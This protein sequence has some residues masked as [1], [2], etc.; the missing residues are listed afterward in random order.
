MS[1]TA[2]IYELLKSVGAQDLD[3]I[4]IYFINVKDSQLSKRTTLRGRISEMFT[5]G[6]IKRDR[7][8]KYYAVLK[9]D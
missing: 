3:Y 7:N 8:G 6:Q 9:N 4:H 1:E 2:R 5:R